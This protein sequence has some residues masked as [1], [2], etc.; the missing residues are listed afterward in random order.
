[1]ETCFS[2]QKDAVLYPES[3]DEGWDS[4]RLVIVMLITPF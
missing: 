3:A 2:G 4:L 1:M